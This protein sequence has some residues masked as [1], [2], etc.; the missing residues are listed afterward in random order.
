MAVATATALIAPPPAADLKPGTLAAFTRYLALTEAGIASTH[1]GQGPFLWI[2]AQPPADRAKLYDRLRAGEVVVAK[3]RTRD[4]GK[5]IDVPDGLIHDWLGTVF[6]PGAT[7]QES[8]RLVQDYDHYPEHFGPLITRA[9]LRA[10]E[11]DRFDVTMRL[12]AKKVITVVLDADYLIDYH[13]EDRRA[14]N[15]S[16]TTRVAEVESA[17]QPDEHEK[18][19]DTGGGYM[20]RAN[21]YCS[22]EQRAEGTYEQCESVSLSRDVPFWLSWIV[23]PFLTTVP[24]E[25][26]EFSLGRARKA[27]AKPG[28]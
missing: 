21:L 4:A 18:P 16:R 3:L 15:A 5:N 25:A 2:D 27:L 8:V 22:F 28:L 9:K 11:D 17:G 6:F 20:W 13:V 26:L 12:Y 14:W 10:R 7:L 24:R 19:P 1:A 23:K